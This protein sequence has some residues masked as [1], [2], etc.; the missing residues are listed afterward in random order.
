MTLPSS[1]TEFDLIERIR[2]RSRL[3]EPVAIGI[4]DDAAVL[5]CASDQQLVIAQDVI[6]EGR[7]FTSD[8]EPELIGRKALAVNLSDL[9]AMA[10]LPTAAFIGLV[11]PTRASAEFADRLYDGLLGLA[12]EFEVTLAGGDTN[13]WDGPLMLSVT[14]LGTVPKGQAVTRGGAT[15]G[16]W[17]C[18]TGALGGSLLSGRHLSFPPRLR[19]AQR[20]R[21]EFHV[22]SMIDLSDGLSGD[23]RHLMA[24]SSVGVRIDA[25]EI[26]VHLDVPNSL[27][28]EQRLERA[29]NDGEDFEL[30]FTLAPEQ[31]QRLQRSDAWNAVPVTKIGEC[32]AERSAL[33]WIDGQ[34]RPLPSGGWRHPLGMSG[35]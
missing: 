15:P 10:A 8:T 31:G 33:L 30:L 25:A 1:L 4:G 26:P 17:L 2:R 11:L 23:L 13:S 20:L 16:D 19:E 32:T 18:V 34:P 22:T 28:F 9:A 24:T 7:H 3:R 12:D 14:V 21:T 6:V 27:G 29:L 5:N 35:D